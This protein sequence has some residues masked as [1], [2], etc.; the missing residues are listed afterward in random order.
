MIIIEVDA[1]RAISYFDG[2][3]KKAPKKFNLAAQDMAKDCRKGARYRL[4]QRRRKS[5]TYYSRKDWLWHSLMVRKAGNAKWE[6][7]QNQAIAPYGPVIEHGITGK[8]FAP[9]KGQGIYGEGVTRRGGRLPSRGGLHFMR[10]AA[11]S[12]MKR[13]RRISER[14]VKELIE[15]G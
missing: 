15:G 7:F 12:T 14:R 4:N 3:V 13:A 8:H 11:D 10:D 2:I 9:V 5:P 6:C 1:K